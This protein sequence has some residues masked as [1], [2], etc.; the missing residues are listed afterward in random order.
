M[1]SSFVFGNGGPKPYLKRTV[2]TR[3]TNPNKEPRKSWFRHIIDLPYGGWGHYA[4]LHCVVILELAPVFNFEMLGCKMK[5]GLSV[6]EVFNLNT[7]SV[8]L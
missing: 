8:Y 3:Y 7:R 5:E 6:R 1:K 4:R 2:C